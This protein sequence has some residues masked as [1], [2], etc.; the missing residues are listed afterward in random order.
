MPM[1]TDRAQIAFSFIM[2]A[3]AGLCLF[4]IHPANLWVAAVRGGLITLFSAVCIY[5]F[6]LLVHGSFSKR[7]VCV[8]T[9]SPLTH[10]IIGWVATL[11]CVFLVMYSMYARVPCYTEHHGMPWWP[12]FINFQA[13][14][15]ERVEGKAV[16]ERF[17]NGYAD[18]IAGLAASYERKQKFKRAL[19]YYGQY[20]DLGDGWPYASLYCEGVI[21][22]VYDELK[23]FE[24]AD[25]HYDLLYPKV[26]ENSKSV[27]CVCQA[28]LLR[29]FQFVPSEIVRAEFPWAEILL[30]EKDKPA[31]EL[32]SQFIQIDFAE[33]DDY[34]RQ[35]LRPVFHP[36]M[37]IENTGE[38][39]AP[40]L[41]ARRHKWRPAPETSVAGHLLRQ[42][43][44]SSTPIV[45][46]SK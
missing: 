44:L 11:I 21:G 13:A 9:F 26:N 12:K 41:E 25:A 5:A 27:E 33:L 36:E 37:L 42:L 16:A 1:R 24:A 35:L 15:I 17:W 30:K 7:V 2:Y 32:G 45:R 10:Q 19:E 14:V 20:K 38:G 6:A 46:D 22:R 3:A 31:L 43:E 34:Q 28:K 4:L 39:Y 40:E 8:A 23:D 29:I 18:Y